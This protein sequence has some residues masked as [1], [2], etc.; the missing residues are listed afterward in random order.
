MK[1]SVNN[2]MPDFFGKKHDAHMKN[3]LQTGVCTKMNNTKIIWCQKQN[4]ACFRAAI[5]IK[6]MPNFTI[7]T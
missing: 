2:L 7:P 3:W 4:G 6:F 1:S 5:Y